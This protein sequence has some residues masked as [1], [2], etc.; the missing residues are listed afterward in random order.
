MSINYFFSRLFGS[1]GG[2]KLVKLRVT[3]TATS[4]DITFKKS[5]DEKA[6]QVDL[7]GKKWKHTFSAKPGDYVYLSAQANQ[8]DRT[9]NIEIVYDHKT[10]R[11]MSSSGNY[12][13]ATA[14]G[15]L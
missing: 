14:G 8:K 13:V 10:Y 9:V 12:A 4:Y 3:G 1:K 7:S 11:S 15:I 5:G 6:T 2:E